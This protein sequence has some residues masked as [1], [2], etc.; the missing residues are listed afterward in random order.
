MTK[1]GRSSFG[2]AVTNIFSH[3]VTFTIT[4]AKTSSTYSFELKAEKLWV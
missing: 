4:R 3:S 1:K 2:F